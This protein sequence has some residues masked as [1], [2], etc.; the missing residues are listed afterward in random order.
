MADPCLMECRY[1]WSNVTKL[2]EKA[3]QHIQKESSR[4]PTIVQSNVLTSL[5]QMSVPKNINKNSLVHKWKNTN[6]LTS[7]PQTD[8]ASFW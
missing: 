4:Y 8:A 5:P 3:N 1:W 2:Q 7:F 6:G